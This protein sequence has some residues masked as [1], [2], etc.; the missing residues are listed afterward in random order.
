LIQETIIKKIRDL[1]NP[2]A[3][4]LH[5]S[6]AVGMERE[7]SDWDIILIVEKDGLGKNGRI[8]IEGQDVELKFHVL[9]DGD[10]SVLNIF[11]IYLQFAKVLWEEGSVGTDL[12]E[13]AKAE[14]AKG[15]NLTDEELRKWKQ[16][17][18]HKI[19][20]MKDDVESLHMFFKHVNVLHN[21]AIRF[22]YEIL[23]NQFSKPYYMAIPEIQEKDPGFKKLLDVLISNEVSNTEKIE[24]GEGVL[25][26]LFK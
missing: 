5:G 11:D 3:I 14:Y 16:F 26:S 24:A 12:L 19:A 6:R 13:K 1:Y 7:H 17:F 23:H 15:P 25:K 22:W 4:L 2:T 10:F 21:N 8:E 9:P 20:G 18:E